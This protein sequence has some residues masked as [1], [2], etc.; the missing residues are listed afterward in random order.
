MKKMNVIDLTGAELQQKLE[1]AHHEL[2][3][4]RFQL[5]IGRLRNYGRISQLRRD[6]ARIKTE[7]SRRRIQGETAQEAEA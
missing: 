1:E 7:Q 4:L 2:F 3:N 5:A 6:I